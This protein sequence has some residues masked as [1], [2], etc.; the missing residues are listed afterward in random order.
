MAT[1]AAFALVAILLT[2]LM[3]IILVRANKKL[4]SGTEDV[5]AVMVGQATEEIK[6]ISAVERLER[7]QA[8]RYIA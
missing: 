8:F 4:A 2:I 5:A 7:K 1:N 6:G 3:R